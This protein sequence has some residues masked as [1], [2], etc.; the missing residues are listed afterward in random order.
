MAC[1]DA[2][3]NTLLSCGWVFGARHFLSAARAKIRAR[4]LGGGGSFGSGRTVIAMLRCRLRYRYLTVSRL[5]SCSSLCLDYWFFI[6]GVDYSL[7]IGCRDCSGCF[8]VVGWAGFWFVVELGT[9]L[10]ATRAKIRARHLGA[11]A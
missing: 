9:F 4:H 7:W 5:A 8:G 6:A 3:A 2:T 1:L 11:R 10:S